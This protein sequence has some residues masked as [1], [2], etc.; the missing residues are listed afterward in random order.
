MPLALILASSSPARQTLLSNLKIPF[1]SASPEIDEAPYPEETVTDLVLRLSIAK[2]EA[3]AAHYPEHLIIGSDQSAHDGKNFLTKPGN[4][5]N[6][7]M[8][9]KN[10]SGKSITFYTGLC[11]L[12]SFTQQ[13]QSCV[14]TY[15]VHFKTLSDGQITRYLQQ[16]Q[17]YGC[18]GSF[19]VEGLGISLFTHVEGKD[20]NT[21]IGLPLIALIDFLEKEG[22]HVP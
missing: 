5:N 7:F 14:E 11:V 13:K 18:A 1:S 6:A 16:E 20:P 19:K 4:F 12:N 22:I 17:P 3:L 10:L 15:T 8:Q 21:L 9:L 2:A